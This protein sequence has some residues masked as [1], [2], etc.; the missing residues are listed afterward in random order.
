[1]PV[2]HLPEA[3]QAKPREWPAATR[4]AWLKGAAAGA[5]V[6]GL[7]L[8]PKLWLSARSYPLVPVADFLPPIPAPLD[9]LCF[10]TLLL[11][12]GAVLAVPRP[13][14]LLVAFLGLAVVYGLWDQSRWQ[15]WFYQYLGL[16]AA[17]AWGFWQPEAQR[18][19]CAL[20]A[21]RLI[22]AATYFWS[23]LHKMNVVFV[24]D[25]FPWLVKPL[26]SVVPP[27]AHPLVLQGGWLAALLE[28]AVGAGLLLPPLRGAAVWLALGMHAFLLACLGPTGHNYNSVVWPWNVAMVLFVLILFWRTPGLGALAVLWPRRC[29]PAR[30]A[31][32]LFGIVPGL[33][34]FGLA[35]AY[36][37]AALYSGNSPVADVV[38]SAA[39]RERLPAGVRPYFQEAEDGTFRLFVFNW[40]MGELNVPP[41]PE[42]RVYRVVARKLAEAAGDSGVVLVITG[43]A[44]RWTGQRQVTQEV[45]GGAGNPPRP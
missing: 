24:T 14:R 20:N 10:G 1:M 23:G 16:L 43:R 41:Y 11:L 32:L 21:C 37:S 33:H 44:D 4:L 30:V 19:E 35:D 27:E 13:R 22:V 40:S 15:P 12:L 38:V 8:S 31:L 18:Q 28:C 5:L 45:I 25:T 9:T 26:L 42:E 7:L 6:M 29:P 3:K 34:V 39:V 36:L 17:V 2:D